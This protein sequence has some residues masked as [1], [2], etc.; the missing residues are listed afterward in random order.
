[1]EETSP[2]YENLDE[3]SPPSDENQIEN[4]PFVYV[5]KTETEEPNEK[6]TKSK[7]FNLKF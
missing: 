1:M 2:L 3:K 6:Y 5:R 7:L 4:K